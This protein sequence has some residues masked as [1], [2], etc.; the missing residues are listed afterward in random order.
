MEVNVGQIIFVL[1]AKN[2]TLL[3]AQVD[4]VVVSRTV[5]GETTQHILVLQNNKKLVLEKLQ[6]PW[7]IELATAKEYLLSEAE[8][9]IDAVIAK[10]GEAASKHFGSPDSLT[11]HEAVVGVDEMM[12][13]VSSEKI[14]VDLGDGKTARVTLPE[15]F[16][17]ESTSS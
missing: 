16:T 2:H 14:T 3:P 11:D 6:T 10:S 17:L 5:R 8:K 4:E 1:N 13:Q 7:F 15:E 9:M 12:Q